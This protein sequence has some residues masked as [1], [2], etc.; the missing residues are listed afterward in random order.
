MG[1]DDLKKKLLQCLEPSSSNFRYEYATW[2]LF[3]DSYLFCQKNISRDILY[4][5]NLILCREDEKDYS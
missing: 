4:I 5:N 1:G 3:S 2:Q